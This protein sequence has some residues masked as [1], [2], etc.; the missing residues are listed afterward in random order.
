MYL[1]PLKGLS[2]GAAL[3][4]VVCPEDA[5]GEVTQMV[6][7]FGTKVISFTDLV[8]P[9]NP[10]RPKTRTKATFKQLSGNSNT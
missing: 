9:R 7:E 6:G 4:V 1:R 5:I 2:L 3:R 10:D 8:P